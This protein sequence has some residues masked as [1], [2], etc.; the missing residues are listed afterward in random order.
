MEKLIAKQIW[1][2]LN[3]NRILHKNYSGFRKNHSIE[4]ALTYIADKILTNMGKRLVTLTV[5]I[6][7]IKAF[8]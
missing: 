1:E 3:A 8:D 6:D 7:L 2:Y 5:L 4:T